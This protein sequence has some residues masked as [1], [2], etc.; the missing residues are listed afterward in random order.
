MLQ[1]LTGAWESVRMC[2]LMWIKG[3]I[4]NHNLTSSCRGGEKS[5]KQEVGGV[6]QEA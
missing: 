2:V 1:G 5:Q 4:R 3:L 6:K